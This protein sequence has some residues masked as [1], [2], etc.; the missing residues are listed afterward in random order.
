VKKAGAIIAGLLIA[1][2]G[3]F[4]ALGLAGAGHGWGSPFF[5]SFIL[6]FAYPKVLL[7]FV[8]FQNPPRFGN[9][10]VMLFVAFAADAILVLA[11]LEEGVEYIARIVRVNGTLSSTLWIGG[12][13]V[14]WFGW[15]LIAA[16]NVLRA[17]PG[18]T[19]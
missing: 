19:P 11:T 15:Q 7:R 2:I 18:R 6:W 17:R 5:V 13:L 9:D 4:L 14:I 1:F 12:W 3:H 10:L 8:A 16:L